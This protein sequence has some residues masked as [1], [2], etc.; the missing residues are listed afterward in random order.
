M[1]Y[2]SMHKVKSESSDLY[3]V[4]NNKDV[5]H[6]EFGHGKIIKF[7]CHGLKAHVRFDSGCKKILDVRS[8]K[9]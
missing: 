3:R 1:T 6:K 4:V 9:R 2:P 7:E 5:F 8:F